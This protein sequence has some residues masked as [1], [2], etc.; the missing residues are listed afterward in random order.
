MVVLADGTRSPWQTVTEDKTRD[1]AIGRIQEEA[2]SFLPLRQAPV[3]LGEPVFAVGNPFGLGLTVTEGIISALPRA[4]GKTTLIQTD[5]AIN[6][7]NSGGP[8]IDH[9]GRVVGVVNARAKAGS[10]VGFVVSAASLTL[11]LQNISAE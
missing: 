11:L 5:A 1:L 10:G 7:G 4:I 8:L 6:P 3:D 2:L 9:H